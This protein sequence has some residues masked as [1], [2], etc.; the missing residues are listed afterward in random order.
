MCKLIAQLFHNFKFVLKIWIDKWTSRSTIRISRSTR[1]IKYQ[2]MNFVCC[3]IIIIYSICVIK[4]PEYTFSV[5]CVIYKTNITFITPAW[6]I[7][8]EFFTRDAAALIIF[9]INRQNNN[10]FKYHYMT[11]RIISPSKHPKLY[12]ISLIY[13]VETS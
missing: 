7:G 13:R 1:S 11:G 2:W 6:I 9:L 12:F 10:D 5:S 3:T 4:R 8:R